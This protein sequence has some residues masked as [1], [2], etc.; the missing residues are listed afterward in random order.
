MQLLLT[1]MTVLSLQFT[2]MSVNETDGQYNH[3][4][5]FTLPDTATVA[6]LVLFLVEYNEP[7]Y[8]AI[9]PAGG[10]WW[11]IFHKGGTL[12]LVCSDPLQVTYA[13]LP[14]DT[15]IRD[16]DITAVTAVPAEMPHQGQN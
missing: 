15:L 4:I 3:P 9:P 13:N 6:D 8:R 7:H 5:E 11:Q 2:R 12:A 10:L 1:V 16:I 14:A